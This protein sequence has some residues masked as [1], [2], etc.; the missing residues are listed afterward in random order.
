M[1]TRLLLISDTHGNLNIINQMIDKTNADI[2]IHAGD[3]G[4]YN[5]SSYQHISSRELL[6]LIKHSPFWRECT[7]DKQTDKQTL[8]DIVKKYNLLGDFPEYL[9]GKKKFI[10]PVYA[11]YGNHEDVRVIRDLKSENPIQ[12][13]YI[14]DEDNIFPITNN[15]EL[16]FS[17]FGIGGNFLVTEK[18]L[19]RPIAGNAGKVWATLHQFGSLYQK[20]QE[21]ESPSIF[22][23]HVSP[24]KEPLLARLMIHFM[25]NFWISGHMGA[26]YN[27]VW[28]Q[29]TIREIDESI[30]WFNSQLK[31]LDALPLHNMTPEAQIAD[32][33]IKR[34]IKREA[35]WFK[36]LWNI[37]LPDVKDGYS[38]INYVKGRFYVESYSA[39]PE[40][41]K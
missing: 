35:Y 6:L 12:N 4:F 30:E 11:V 39:I 17:L 18:L 22:V 8:I 1:S 19:R 5:E 7:V 23:S 34:E 15:D 24:G 31:E 29:F 26:P 28:N 16:A 32:D 33:L 10:K 3:F 27:C 9:A 40:I 25:P 20:L 41:H 36:N 13:L 37:N 38:V 21:K 14:L 2:V